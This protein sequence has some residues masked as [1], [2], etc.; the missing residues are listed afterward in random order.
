M[1]ENFSFI[2]WVCTGTQNS[3]KS[4]KISQKW[5]FLQYNQGVAV[6]HLFTLC[7]PIF[8][9]VSLKDYQTCKT[10]F[11]L[12]LRSPHLDHMLFLGESRFVTLSGKHSISPDVTMQIF[13]VIGQFSKSE[14]SDWL[15]DHELD[16]RS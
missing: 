11:I 16:T 9:G 13:T 12:P 1:P 15:F 8:G 5:P 4:P 10:P 3:P 7:S 6:Y 14:R 2:F